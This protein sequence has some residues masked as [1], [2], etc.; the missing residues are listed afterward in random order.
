MKVLITTIPFASKNPLPIK[1]LEDAGVEYEINPLNR[2]LTEKDLYGLLDD[3]DVIIAGTE[4][5]SERVMKKNKNLKMISRVGIGLDSVNLIAA[6]KNGITVSYTPD[7]PSPAVVD[8]TLG[9]IYTLLRHVHTSNIEMHNGKWE[10]YFGKRL[11]EC[12]V[13][14]IGNGRIGSG[15]IKKLISLKPKAILVNDLKKSDEYED[16]PGVSWS[17]I[18]SI[19]SD[20]DIVSI[21]VPLQRLL[22]T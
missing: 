1:L 19:L 8:L 13:G 18:D 14:I 2:K 16:I 21:H 3:H 17:G 15:V 11:S 10:R 4:E 9:F 12:V 6:E 22:K 5:I 20:S 7:A